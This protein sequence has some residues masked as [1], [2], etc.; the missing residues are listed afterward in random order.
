MHGT[1]PRPGPPAL[2]G[3]RGKGVKGVFAACSPGEEPPLSKGFE[4]AHPHA[5]Q[6]VE[7]FNGAD[8]DDL[9][10]VRRVP[11]GE[12][13]APEAVARDG[14]VARALEPVMEA[15]LLHKGGDPLGLCKA[16]A[17]NDDNQ[18]DAFDGNDRK[19]AQS[20]REDAGRGNGGPTCALH[21]RRRSLIDSTLTNH[22]GTAR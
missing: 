8:A 6:L 13:R 7:L 2:G 15:L 20:N 16:I 22:D 17:F 21:A 9:L 3:G 10:P 11:D 4:G 19:A 12:G 18:N 1:R 14:P 5:R